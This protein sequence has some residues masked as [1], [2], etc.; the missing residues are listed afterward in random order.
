MFSTD[1]KNAWAGS[2]IRMDPQLLGLP[3]PDLYF[4][5]TDLVPTE[6]FTDPQ[7]TAS[8]STGIEKFNTCQGH[9]ESY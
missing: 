4:R 6:T 8:N 3:D 9:P 7:Y 1:H 2:G 5:I